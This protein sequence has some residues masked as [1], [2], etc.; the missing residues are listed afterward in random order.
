MTSYGIWDGSSC[1]HCVEQNCYVDN[2]VNES[3]PCRHCG[4]FRGM[5]SG[6]RYPPGYCATSWR[7]ATERIQTLREEFPDVDKS[8]ISQ[9]VQASGENDMEAN[10]ARN[11]LEAHR[12]STR[13]SSGSSDLQD[14]DVSFAMA[15]L[16]DQKKEKQEYRGTFVD[17][18][19]TRGMESIALGIAREMK[20]I[21]D[22]MQEGRGEESCDSEYI[23]DV[24]GWSFNREFDKDIVACVIAV[25]QASTGCFH[26]NGGG[27]EM[28]GCSKCKIARFCN[29]ECQKASWKQGFLGNDEEPHKERCPTLC[30]VRSEP[31]WRTILEMHTQCLLEGTHALEMALSQRTIPFLDEIVRCSSASWRERGARSL[32]NLDV[33]I[34]KAANGEALLTGH[35]M[36]LDDKSQAAH[37]GEPGDPVCLM[38]NVL[39]RVLESGYDELPEDLPEFMKVAAIS[40]MGAFLKEAKQRDISIMCITASDGARWLYEKK[41]HRKLCLAAPGCDVKL[42]DKKTRQF[43]EAP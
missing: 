23:S 9:H 27:R 35:T 31:G 3:T 32:I 40:H 38:H 11:L 6:S 5:F 4:W 19:T 16:Q 41:W 21:R 42:S 8:I 13:L 7:Y 30:A 39:F 10:G 26:C 1:P 37:D 12:S 18:W 22:K 33:S 20:S 25:V 15:L 2:G 28:K 43:V 14:D 36:F 17:G 24:T 34:Q 29:K